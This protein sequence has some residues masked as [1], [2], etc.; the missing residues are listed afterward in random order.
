MFSDKHNKPDKPVLFLPN[1]CDLTNNGNEKGDSG[2][3][4]QE[5]E[6]EKETEDTICKY[7]NRDPC[8]ALDMYDLLAE[9]GNV[10]KENDDSLTN[11]NV[12]FQLYCLA[13]EQI[14]GRLG[15][16]HHIPLPKCVQGDIQDLYPERNQEY[17]GFR[18]AADNM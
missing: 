18:E 7:C 4:N 11:K 3:D 12:Q 16:G 15:T 8:A 17:V 5:E 6:E 14:H 10:L 9:T 1:V 13:S 2:D